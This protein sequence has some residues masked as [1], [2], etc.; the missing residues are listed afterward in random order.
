MCITNYSVLVVAHATWHRIWA[1]DRPNS[2]RGR[3]QLIGLTVWEPVQGI[4][5]WG[6]DQAYVSMET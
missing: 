5:T 3:D 1:V 4:Q 6:R 2:N